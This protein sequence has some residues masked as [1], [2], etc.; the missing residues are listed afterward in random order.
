MSLF[1]VALRDGNS[2]QEV[3]LETGAVLSTA[4]SLE[5]ESFRLAWS[6]GEPFGSLFK[7][8]LDR[9]PVELRSRQGSSS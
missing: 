9:A 2:T 4:H 6:S 1:V 3:R 7:P 8:S 5:F